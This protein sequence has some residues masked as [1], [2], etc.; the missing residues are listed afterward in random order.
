M[1][2]RNRLALEYDGSSGAVF[3]IES[4]YS[5]AH[6][7]SSE[8]NW[9]IGTIVSAVDHSF[10]IHFCFF[11]VHAVSSIVDG[12]HDG[13]FVV[14]DGNGASVVV[15][16]NGSIKCFSECT[17]RNHGSPVAVNIWGSIH[18]E[19]LLVNN[20]FGRTNRHNNIVMSGDVASTCS[21]GQR[22]CI[23][24]FVGSIVNSY[25]NVDFRWF[26]SINSQGTFTIGNVRGFNSNNGV[27]VALISHISFHGATYLC[28]IA[29]FV[30]Y[31]NSYL[32]VFVNRTFGWIKFQAEAVVRINNSQFLLNELMVSFGES[33]DSDGGADQGFVSS[34]VIL[35]SEAIAIVHISIYNSL[36]IK[37]KVHVGSI[38]LQTIFVNILSADVNV[39]AKCY[40]I[41]DVNSSILS[42]SIYCPHIQNSILNSAKLSYI[43]GSFGVIAAIQGQTYFIFPRNEIILTVAAHIL[44]RVYAM[45]CIPIQYKISSFDIGFSRSTFD[46]E[47]FSMCFTISITIV[48]SRFAVCLTIGQHHITI[49]IKINKR[50]SDG[51]TSNIIYR[52]LYSVSEYTR[53][54]SP[55]TVVT[56]E[57]ISTI[58]SSVNVIRCGFFF[59]DV[60][61][62]FCITGSDGNRNISVIIHSE[63]NVEFTIVIRGNLN[64]ISFGVFIT[65]KLEM[66]ISRS[67]SNGFFYRT[68]VAFKCVC[69]HGINISTVCIKI[70][71]NQ[72]DFCKITFIPG[73]SIFRASRVN[74]DAIDHRII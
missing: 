57:N 34:N 20:V 17:D 30:D 42:A 36:T 33:S 63:G 72:I 18:G 44:Q 29:I 6:S 53:I 23:E 26:G 9:Y 65:K 27:F 40:F 48:C 74:F 58:N 11:T 19:E 50:T 64:A 47:F 25:N 45:V 24:A 3:V 15:I 39:L 56:C 7:F 70:F 8:T 62:I 21:V 14:L 35:G 10:S 55:M 61:S 28:T 2:V 52:E 43:E 22:T 16:G 4:G 46:A 1:I 60:Q 12:H 54:F 69:V 49:S 68:L 5:E 51:F 41:S 67:Q 59:N 73:Q 66:S 71:T 31:R 32:V 38:D 13:L 37:T